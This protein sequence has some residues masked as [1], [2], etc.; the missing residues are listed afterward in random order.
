MCDYI[1]KG[2]CAGNGCDNSA[3]YK[4]KYAH[5][6]RG[7]ICYAHCP[8]GYTCTRRAGHKRVHEA[9][10]IKAYARWKVAP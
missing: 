5:P 3:R 8:D 10:G 6:N 4:P 2:K 1:D 7:K 9:V